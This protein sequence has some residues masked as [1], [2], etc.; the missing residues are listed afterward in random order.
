MGLPAAGPPT[1]N[2]PCVPSAG[3]LRQRLQVTPVKGPGGTKLRITA[4]VDRKLAAC[5]L[6]LLLG[7]VA[8]MTRSSSL[9]MAGV[10]S[11]TREVPGR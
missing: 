2:T 10:V 11:R 8:G 4:T 5:P 1:T 7:G 6:R 3:D 9:R